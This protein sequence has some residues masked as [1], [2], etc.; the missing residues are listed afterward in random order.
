MK[1]DNIN[2]PNCLMGKPIEIP[3]LGLIYPLT[4]NEIIEIGMA[5]YNQYLSLLTITTDDILNMI[6]QV[7]AEEVIVLPNNSNIILAAEQAKSLSDK[8][9][10]VA[11]SKF[12]T[13]GISSMLVFNPDQRAEVNCLAM[14]DTF[15]QIV[16]GELTYAV[17]STQI[18]GKSIKKNDYLG[19]FGK[20]E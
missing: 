13:Q 16:N 5:T 8:N 10:A 9:I 6:E 3:T 7:P 15:N 14:E 2:M 19:L 17:R 20:I 12:V 18:N 11:K 1:N 4:L